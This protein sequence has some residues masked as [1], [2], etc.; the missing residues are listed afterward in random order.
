VPCK[1]KYSPQNE[2]INHAKEKIMSSFFEGFRG[3]IKVLSVSMRPGKPLMIFEIRV[4]PQSRESI[5]LTINKK[6]P[7]WHDTVLLLGNR[8]NLVVF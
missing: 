4:P 2:D 6:L 1:L 5:P 8:T 3:I 7:N